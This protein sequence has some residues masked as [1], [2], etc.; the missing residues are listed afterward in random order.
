MKITLH[1]YRRCPF[2]IRVRIVLYLKGV[3]YERVHEPLRE[4]TS[5][6][7]THISH[8]RVPVLH[9][10]NKNKDI[11][12]PESNNINVWL[13]SNFGEQLY[14]PKEGSQ[15]YNEMITWWKWCDEKFKP[16]IDVYKYGED[17]VFDDAKHEE[18]AT[19]LQ[20]V[21]GELEERLMVSS[22]LT[23]DSITLADIAIIP[24]VRQI[25][26]IRN[27]EFDLSLYPRV[28]KWSGE[29]LNQS[30][31]DDIVMKKDKDT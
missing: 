6:M 1:D 31:F 11:I 28:L 22:H 29:I 20:I 23:G 2:C 25:M 16:V 9:I 30:W 5:W 21:V 17:R 10:Q 24:F 12:M 4:W 7:L 26:R 14:T 18:H 13:D 27:A 15:E 8:P 19:S 3:E